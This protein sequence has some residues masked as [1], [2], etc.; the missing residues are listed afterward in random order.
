MR[1][2]DCLKSRRVYIIAEM[3]G[4]HGGDFKKALDI[5]H[6][7]AEAGA[8]CL[9]TQTYTA[10]TLTIDCDHDEFIVKGG[11]WNNEKLYD[12]YKKGT[13]PWEWQEK[14]KDECEKLGL[15][16]MSTPFDNSA[17]DFLEKIG[18]QLY[19][20]ASPELVDIPLIEY[21]ARLKKPVFVSLGES[22]ESE[23]QDAVDALEKHGAKYTLLKCCSQYPSDYK[24]MNLNTINILKAKFN[25]P[26]GLSDHSEGSLGPIIATS[27]GA[28]VIEKH[29]CLD[30]ND[31]TAVD[32]KFS[33]TPGSFK[34]MVQDVRDTE[35]ILGRAQLLPSEGEL[36]GLKNRRSLYVVK[37][38]RKGEIFT[39]DNIRSIRP[40]KGLP[41]KFLP[42]V[43]GKKA[44]NNISFGT[45]M[46]WDLIEEN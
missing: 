35:L 9:K 33:M 42:E 12:L 4:N 24:N 22:F 38:V 34:K 21:V 19:K 27:L 13:T 10:D 30:N 2:S 39:A 32:A 7:A 29:L 26:I 23:M 25:C 40:A 11:L 37:P 43:L 17:V 41:P 6:A 45:P 3:S 36:R 8:D 14:I 46:S 16:F 28:T 5:V 1:Y 20:I 44:K 15:D 18:C 31:E